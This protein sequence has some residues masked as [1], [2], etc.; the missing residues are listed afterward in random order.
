MVN[1]VSGG[2]ADPTCCASSPTRAPRSSRCTC[3]AR[4]ATMQRRRAA[5]PTSSR[6]VG[7]EL[8]ARVDAAVARRHRRARDCSPIP[9]IGFAKTAEHNLALLRALPEIA[10]RVGA[11]LLVGTSRKSFL[12]AH[13]RR[14][15]SRRPRR[16]HARHDGLVLRAGCRAGARA[17]RRRDRDARSRC[18]TSSNGR[19]PKG[20]RRDDRRPARALGPGPAAALLHVGDQGPPRRGRAARRLRPQPSQGAAPGRADLAATSTASRTSSRC[21]TRRTT[22]TRTTRPAWRTCTCRSVRTTSSRRGSRRS[23]AR[24]TKLL[25]DPA[26]RVYVHNEEFGDRVLGVLAGYLLLRGPRRARSA[27]DLGRSRS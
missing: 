6:E 1:D 3:A 5:T 27:R 17:R 23:T 22:C 4:R 15:R 21:S 16:R 8:R 11:P 13:R 19:H 18:S 24:S 12:A 20:W 26:E 14:R 2:T 10:A 25:D 7:D 9:G